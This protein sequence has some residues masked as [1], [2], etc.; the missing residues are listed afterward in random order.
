MNMIKSIVL[1]TTFS[2]VLASCVEVDLVGLTLDLL[3]EPSGGYVD[4]K[5][6]NSDYDP[7]LWEVSLVDSLDDYTIHRSPLIYNDQV[8][9][10]TKSEGS[11]R[12]KFYNKFSGTLERNSVVDI[13]VSFWNYLAVKG[14]K[15]LV[16]TSSKIYA[17]SAIDLSQ[18][19]I[20]NFEGRLFIGDG[21]VFYD[22]NIL[23]PLSLYPSIKEIKLQTISLV[24]GVTLKQD[25]VESENILSIK[26]AEISTFQLKNDNGYDEVI[27][28]TSG[29]LIDDIPY[30]Q[31]VNFELDNSQVNW[32]WN[33]I[34]EFDR[35]SKMRLTDNYAF[36]ISDSLYVLERSTGLKINSESITYPEYD[37]SFSPE[38]RSLED[39]IIYEI[40]GIGIHSV[41]LPNFDIIWEN[42][43]TSIMGSKDVTVNT[44]YNFSAS[45][46]LYR[47][48]LLN[49]E[50]KIWDELP[51]VLNYL[52]DEF[53]IDEENNIL[54]FKDNKRLFAT[55]MD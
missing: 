24:N 15:L 5:N 32:S 8:I 50:V 42:R 2:C 17:I 3:P 18:I 51:Y 14:D 9:M 39:V 7:L 40:T 13:G 38:I 1:I 35:K 23:L 30:V 52:K 11:M 6:P 4:K 54:Y 25:I 53:S 16:V 34:G 12:F 44:I 28:G 48:N 45:E 55:Q 36:I 20:A 29:R 37:V 47:L 46:N 27:I 41:N 10:V 43:N 33:K 26:N 21:L 22:G 19:W 31:F 49:G